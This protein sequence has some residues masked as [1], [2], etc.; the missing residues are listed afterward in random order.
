MEWNDKSAGKRIK[1]AIV[2]V[3]RKQSPNR[4]NMTYLI[5]HVMNALKPPT[6]DFLPAY[7][8]VSEYIHVN[9][10]KGKILSYRAGIAGG[11]AVKSTTRKA[12]RVKR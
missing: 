10:G 9:T 2:S 5:T 1:A 12:R 11:Y 7:Q 4:A 8:A 3:L 6:S